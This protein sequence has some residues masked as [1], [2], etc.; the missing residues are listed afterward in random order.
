MDLHLLEGRGGE[1]VE[2]GGL[3]DLADG[4]RETACHDRGVG[5]DDH[6]A[7]M[8]S[9]THIPYLARHCR[10]KMVGSLPRGMPK[11]LEYQQTGAQATN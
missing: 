9:C 1:A 6:L 7:R 10:R 2:A 11:V 4:E 8:G 3:G 5:H